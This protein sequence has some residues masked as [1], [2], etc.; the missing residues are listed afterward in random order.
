MYT[1]DA[2]LAVHVSLCIYAT[3]PAGWTM[4]AMPSWVLCYQC[5]CLCTC[6]VD[7]LRLVLQHRRQNLSCNTAT[8]TSRLVLQHRNTNV[9]TCLATPTLSTSSFGCPFASICLYLPLS[10][11]ICLYLPLFASI[12]LYLPLFASTTIPAHA[13]RER[14][15]RY[16]GRRTTRLSERKGN[17]KGKP[18]MQTR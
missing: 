18:S 11:S 4:H 13:Q 14:G 16:L 8:P 15:G 9:K 6:S 10:A 1:V 3:L 5:L 12:C 7:I 2:A 17:K